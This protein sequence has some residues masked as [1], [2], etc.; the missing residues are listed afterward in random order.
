MEQMPRELLDMVVDEIAKNRSFAS[1][2]D[3]RNIRLV[4]KALSQAALA[5]LFHTI[6]VWW[7]G[8][9]SLQDLTDLSNHPEM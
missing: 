9:Q 2:Q 1:R 3:L 5:T 8:R 7:F 4:N 6:F